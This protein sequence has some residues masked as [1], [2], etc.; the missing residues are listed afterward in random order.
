MFVCICVCVPSKREY[1]VRT[2]SRSVR[3]YDK[4]IPFE[5]A[6]ALTEIKTNKQTDQVVDT[7]CTVII[8]MYSCIRL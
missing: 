6:Q 5:A 1:S 3:L 4:D 8:T 2:E 7:L